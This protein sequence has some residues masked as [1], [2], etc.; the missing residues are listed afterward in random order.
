MSPNA[1]RVKERQ[2]CRQSGRSDCCVHESRVRGRSR[3]RTMILAR[4]PGQEVLVQMA[5][6]IVQRPQGIGRCRR[7]RAS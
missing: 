6:S 5:A 4:S 7:R 1:T 3:R 2:Q